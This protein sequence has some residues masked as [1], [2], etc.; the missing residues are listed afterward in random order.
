LEYFIYYIISYGIIFIA[1]VVLVLFTSWVF[2]EPG[3]QM[4][5]KFI[6]LGNVQG[7]TKD[8]IIDVVGPPQ[9]KTVIDDSKTL[10]KWKT[11]GYL[12]VLEFD[13]EICQ[14]VKQDIT[15]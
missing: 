12:I 4:K 11:I 6:A 10:L 15:S 1:V 9:N 14:G 13:A 3:R 2:R 7:L 8:F 5:K